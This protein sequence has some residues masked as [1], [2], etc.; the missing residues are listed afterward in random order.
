MKRARYDF[1]SL[2]DA[3]SFG[4]RPSVSLG[5]DPSPTYEVYVKLTNGTRVVAAHG[6]TR[7]QAEKAL[8]RMLRR[9]RQEKALIHTLDDAFVDARK[10][11]RVYLDAH[12]DAFAAIIEDTV[13]EGYRIYQGDRDGCRDAVLEA[14]AII[15]T[16][17]DGDVPL[18]SQPEEDDPFSR[19]RE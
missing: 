5:D 15:K 13:G 2:G 14:T 18:D 17:H 8:V 4:V 12:A 7:P 11:V 16:L 3:V 9:I 10:I 1:Y 19:S 6:G